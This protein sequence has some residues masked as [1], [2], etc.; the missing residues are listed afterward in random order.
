MKQIT[1]ELHKYY[2]DLEYNDRDLVKYLF[3]KR[4]VVYEESHRVRAK[5]HHHTALLAII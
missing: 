3:I 5:L 1:V 4:W 2:I